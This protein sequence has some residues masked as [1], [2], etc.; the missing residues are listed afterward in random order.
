MEN[1]APKRRGR[2]PV[3]AV[4]N[5][6]APLLDAAPVAEAAPVA[7]RAPVRPA[8]RE[9]DPRAR[10]AK[11][12]AEIKGNIGTLD[13]GVDEFIAPT[14]PDGWTYEWKTKTVMGQENP[15]YQVQLQRTGWEPVPTNRHPHMM[16]GN[17]NHAVIERKGMVLMERPKDITD[18]VRSIERKRARDQIMHKKAQLGEA[19]EGQFGRDHASVKPKISNSYEPIPVPE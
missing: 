12:S 3:K 13:E 4:I 6:E 14:A 2:P 19:K 16:P 7:S 18:E 17:G 9:E 8:L 11:R 1:S 10:A 15:A 5:K